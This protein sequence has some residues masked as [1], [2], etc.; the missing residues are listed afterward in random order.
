MQYDELG[1]KPDDNTQF[2]ESAPAAPEPW[3]W[4]QFVEATNT[5]FAVCDESL[6]YVKVNDALARMNGIA[7]EDHLGKTIYDVLGEAADECVTAFQQVFATGHSLSNC[8]L[9]VKLPSRSTSGRWLANYFPI[10][11]EE[12]QVRR[13]GV[14][15]VELPV[16]SPPFTGPQENSVSPHHLK[17]LA[18]FTTDITTETREEDLFIAT[19]GILGKTL[20]PDF[21]AIALYDES[22]GQMRVYA[23]D[24]EVS[25]LLGADLRV[26]VTDEACGTAYLGAETVIYSRSQLLASRSDCLLRLAEA[27][28]E[29][30]CC[31]PLVNA[32]GTVGTLNL[33]WKQ[34]RVLT[35]DLPFLNLLASRIALSLHNVHASR[36][37][38]RLSRKLRIMALGGESELAGENFGEIIGESRALRK[39]LTQVETVAPSDAT[40][41]ILG[42]TGT[43]KELVA[44][45]IH[46]LSSRR[47]GKFVKLNC[48][49]IPTGL[50]ESELFGHEKGAFTGAV[51]Q[52]IGRLEVADGG[53]LFLDEI[54]EIPLEVQP[55]LLRVLEDQEFER[56]G[57]TRTIKVN[58]RVLAATNRDLAQCVSSREFRSDLYYRL[59]VFPV[60]VPPLRERENDIDL[61]VRYFV[62]KFARSMH[63]KITGISAET[64]TALNSWHWP[65]N[66]RELENF[67]E[68]SVI[69]SEGLTL[70]APLGELD[71]SL[72]SLSSSLRNNVTL[73]NIEREHILRVL[74]E[75]DG[76]IAGVRGAAA[77][78]GMKRTTLQSRM[79]KLGITREEYQ[80]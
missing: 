19:S 15:V 4:Q 30:L 38:K 26:P 73:E 78:L 2:L 55:K 45:A 12:G 1:E 61:L 23:L 35:E 80:N 31:L 47:D 32:K 16:L 36:E 79:Q 49:A 59:Y 22:I 54:G 21:A 28:T 76:V 70:S 8:N 44:R 40:V 72:L 6:R 25:R 75:A 77:R 33:A 17:A 10:R 29:S 18:E 57:S 53:T 56:L 67:I 42:E 5:G 65:G 20:Q 39:V 60:R 14:V 69:L 74:R 62:Q 43:G 24:F 3:I 7:A 52:K 51:Q 41:L 71:A 58:I 34:D 63:K 13:V 11:D 46:R 64:M 66:V 48:A 27:G 9:V 37:I 50:I 68:R